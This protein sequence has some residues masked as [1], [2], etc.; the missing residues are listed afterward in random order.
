MFHA[1]AVFHTRCGWFAAKGVDKRRARLRHLRV[2][3]GGGFLSTPASRGIGL[4]HTPCGSFPDNR[5]DNRRSALR[6]GQVKRAG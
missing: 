4:F 3:M 5:V 6:D 2:K 1:C